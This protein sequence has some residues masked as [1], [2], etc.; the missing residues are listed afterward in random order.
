MF[1]KMFCMDWKRC[2]EWKKIIVM[3]TALV[4]FYVAG[5]QG[6][7][8]QALF[9]SLSKEWATPSIT[10]LQFMLGFD[11]YKILIVF[12]ISTI[13]T[14]SY[15]SDAR[16]NYLRFILAR[17]DITTYTQ[18]RFLANTVAITLTVV[19]SFLLYALILYPV[20]PIWREGM[21]ASEIYYYA[22]LKKSPILYLLM[23]GV[24]FGLIASACSSMGLLFSVYQNNAFVTI[25]VSGMSLFCLLSYVPWGSPFSFLKIVSMEPVFVNQPH[26]FNYTWGLFLPTLLIVGCGFLFY[27]RMKWRVKYGLI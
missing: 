8:R 3:L 17:V 19:M 12:L 1:W 26:W 9:Y 24:Q 4:L 15:C 7:I 20:F 27:R 10:M 11:E 13:Y 25:C 5:S 16:S 14:T 6:E 23:M 2:F 18:V 21:N 22:I